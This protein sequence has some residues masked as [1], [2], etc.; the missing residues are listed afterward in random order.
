MRVAFLD[1][2]SDHLPYHEGCVVS[3]DIVNLPIVLVLPWCTV[4]FPDF[5]VLSGGGE[6]FP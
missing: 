5:L 4:Q 1:G 2:Q 3:R 6:Q